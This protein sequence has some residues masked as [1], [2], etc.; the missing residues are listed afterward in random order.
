MT[1]GSRIA[2]W[3]AGNV[4]AAIWL[5]NGDMAPVPE[6]YKEVIQITNNQ[7]L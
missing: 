4:S 2:E 1:V 7:T 3:L 5:P 6:P